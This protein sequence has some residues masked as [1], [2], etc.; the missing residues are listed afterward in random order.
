MKWPCRSDAAQ[1]PTASTIAMVRQRT[2]HT[3]ITRGSSRDWMDGHSAPVPH[4]SLT[5]VLLLVLRLLS[6]HYY[7]SRGGPLRMMDYYY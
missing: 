1:K 6:D 7:C 5:Q 4:A 2:F 3:S